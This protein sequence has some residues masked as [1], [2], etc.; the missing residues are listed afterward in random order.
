MNR[1]LVLLYISLLCINSE[2]QTIHK[3]V[4]Y[5]TF[6]QG[7]DTIKDS[8]PAYILTYDSLGRL[9]SEWKL[10]YDTFGNHSDSFLSVLDTNGNLLRYSS[11]EYKS[12]YTYDEYGTRIRHEWTKGG[13]KT[14]WVSVP[15]YNWRHKPKYI[16]SVYDQNDTQF[17]RYNYFF[18][19]VFSRLCLSIEQSK[20]CVY[21]HDKKHW[22]NGEP[23]FYKSR[24]N[25]G[26]T[27]NQHMTLYKRSLKGRLKTYYQVNN[28]V[29]NKKT[30][31]FYKHGL[32]THQIEWFKHPDYI[33]YTEF[34]YEYW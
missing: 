32:E 1:L 31:H 22:L 23:V 27:K 30:Q 29:I 17:V 28:H 3:K 12:I 33:L 10:G 21:S 16:K 19:H 2:G 11:S 26:Y 34:T 25:F 15:E 13:I 7:A 4:G 18:N 6:I 9:L 24:Y 8:I 14:V 20:E 5:T